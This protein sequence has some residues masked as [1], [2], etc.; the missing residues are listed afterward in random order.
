MFGYRHCIPDMNRPVLGFFSASNQTDNDAT[1]RCCRHTKTFWLLF[2]FDILLF[3][4]SWVLF[5]FS[6]FLFSVSSADTRGFGVFGTKM[7][8]H[9][10]DP[11]ILAYF[12]FVVSCFL[13]LSPE[14]H[15]PLSATA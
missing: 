12:V 11:H 6:L 13:S 9:M 7:E 4:H 3:L 2:H 14:S 1:G 8:A 5:Y 15:S 10:N